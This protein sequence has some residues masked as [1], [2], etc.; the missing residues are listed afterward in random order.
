MT[1]WPNPLKTRRLQQSPQCGK[2]LYKEFEVAGVAP[3]MY[4]I[5]NE[6]SVRLKCVMTDNGVNYQLVTPHSHRDN[7]SERAI[8]AFKHHFKAILAGVDPQF[9]IVLWDLLLQQ[10]T[11]TLN[12]LMSAQINPKLSTYSCLKGNFNFN[13]T[14]LFPPGARLLSYTRPGAK[15]TWALN[16]E[17]GWYVGPAMEYYQ[18][19]SVYSPKTASFR[20]V[21]TVVFVPTRIPIPQFTLKDHLREAGANIVELL[22]KLSKEL[23]ER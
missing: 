22:E 2:K 18:N 9:L 23:K 14:P 13:A 16:G 17:E 3:K 7:I 4:V 6:A 10:T 1:L 8:Q 5:D 21:D 12:L 19:V 20:Q 11:I 15:N